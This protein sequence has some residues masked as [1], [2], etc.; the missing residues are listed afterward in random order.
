[1]KIEPETTLDRQQGKGV[2]DDCLKEPCVVFCAS[3]EI[4]YEKTSDQLLSL[5]QS[6]LCLKLLLSVYEKSVIV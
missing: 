3:M 6:I 4:R 2:V 5:L 1:M